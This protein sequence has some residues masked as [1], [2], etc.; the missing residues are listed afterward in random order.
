[1]LK[2]FLVAEIKDVLSCTGKNSR[3]DTSHRSQGTKAIYSCCVFINS[4]SSIIP[5]LGE[6]LGL[7]PSSSPCS[8]AMLHLACVS[9]TAD[10]FH[11]LVSGPSKHLISSIFYLTFQW[12]STFGLIVSDVPST[13]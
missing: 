4:P 13:L 10:C 12:L 3:A 6:M 2:C 8:K 5:D 1:M 11:A 7:A 9:E